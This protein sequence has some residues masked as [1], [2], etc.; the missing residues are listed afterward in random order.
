MSQ[1][2]CMM[3]VSGHIKSPEGKKVMALGGKW[4]EYLHCQR[5]DEEGDPLP[6][7]PKT[8]L[9]T[10][11][12][13]RLCFCSV[14][15][16]LLLSPTLRVCRVCHTAFSASLLTKFLHLTTWRCTLVEST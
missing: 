6:D 13:L 3:Q 1:T 12:L 10:V 14:T 5:C 15:A 7:A 11:C 9:W 8:R 16:S 2:A 4:N